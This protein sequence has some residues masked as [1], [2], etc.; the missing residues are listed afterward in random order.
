MTDRLS[1]RLSKSEVLI[2]YWDK[3]LGHVHTLASE[4]QD[5][6]VLELCKNII[7]I[8]D[9]IRNYILKQFVKACRWL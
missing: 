6:P 7:L 9:E 1:T 4:Y 2:N 3:L 5:K 8:P